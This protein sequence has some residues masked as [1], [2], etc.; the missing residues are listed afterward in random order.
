MKMNASRGAQIGILAGFYVVARDYSDGK[1]LPWA[2]SDAISQ[3]IVRIM[4]S[5]MFMVAVCTLLGAAMGWGITAYQRKKSKAQVAT[6]PEP[7]S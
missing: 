6:S 5:M 3:N 1:F 2:G 4:G 7:K